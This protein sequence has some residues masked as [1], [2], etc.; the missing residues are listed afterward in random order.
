MPSENMLFCVAVV[1]AS[2]P[3]FRTHEK[4]RLLH[5]FILPPPPHR[6]C[7]HHKNFFFRLLARLSVCVCV[8]VEGGIT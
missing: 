5:S 1:V 3:L 6:R 4:Y 8:R 2:L 7:P